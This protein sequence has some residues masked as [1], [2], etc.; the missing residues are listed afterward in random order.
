GLQHQGDAVGAYA[1][2]LPGA[3]IGQAVGLHGVGLAIEDMDAA[4][5]VGAAGAQNGHR[6]AGAVAL[7]EVGPAD[8]DVLVPVQGKA[9][10][11]AAPRRADDQFGLCSGVGEDVLLVAGFA[12]GD[13]PGADLI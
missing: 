5:G 10:D 4:V 12:F 3:Q 9:G 1:V 13:V 6:K 11:H 2:H 8:P 7:A